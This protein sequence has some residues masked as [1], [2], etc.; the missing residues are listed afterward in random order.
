VISCQFVPIRYIDTLGDVSERLLEVCQANNKT[1]LSVAE[2][3][4][5]V[6]VENSLC[7]DNIAY[8]SSISGTDRIYKLS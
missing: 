6:L 2:K 4:Y 1:G 3:M 7:V 5:K 8:T